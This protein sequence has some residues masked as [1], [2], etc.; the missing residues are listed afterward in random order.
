M[1]SQGGPDQVSPRIEVAAG[2]RF[3]ATERVERRIRLRGAGLALAGVLLC[4]VMGLAITRIPP[5]ML[6]GGVMG[7]FCGLIILRYPYGGLLL[8]TIVYM[9]RPAENYPALAPLRLELVVGLL[10]SV[11]MIVHRFRISS[12]LEFDASRVSRRLVLVFL[13]VALSVPFSYQP[14]LAW[15]GLEAFL[16]LGVWYLLVVHLVTTRLRFRLFLSVYLTAICK[17]AFDALRSYFGGGYVKFAQGID[18]LVGQNSAA[19]DPNNFAATCAA[20]I[21][22][23]LLLASEKRLRWYRALPIAGAAVLSVSLNLTG[24]RSGLLG[25]LAM[26]AF[27]WAKTRNRLV[28]GLVGALL[29]VGGFSILPDQYKTRYSTITA[30]E[31]DASSQA[32]IRVWKK[33]LQMVAD[34]PLTGVGINCFG[35]ANALGYSSQGQHSWLQSHSLYVQVPAEI[36]LIGAVLFFSFL[37]ELLRSAKLS[38]QGL[39]RRRDEFWFEETTLRGLTAGLIALLVTGIFGHSLMRETWYLYG[40]IIVATLRMQTQSHSKWQMPTAWV[41]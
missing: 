25:F 41:R 13:A 30:E 27:L 10:T 18:R 33:G 16:K 6:I 39:L 1:G 32:R 22:I 31:R 19:G 9:W 38:R 5:L 28:I 40:A 34:R 14:A 37:F 20:T 12:C 21:P 4:A 29:L 23:L 15:A 24:S 17:L 36:G 2:E 35:A 7:L 3:A 26:L 11:A 8:Y